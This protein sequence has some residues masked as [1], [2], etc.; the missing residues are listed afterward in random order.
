MVVRAW[1]CRFRRG[2]RCGRLAF[3]DFRCCVEVI[4]FG[5]VDSSTRV[6]VSGIATATSVSAGSFHSCALL[7]S[8]GVQCWGAGANG[9]LSNG[10][11]VDG[12]TPVAVF[13]ISNATRVGAGGSHTCARLTNGE[14]RCWRTNSSGQLGDGLSMLTAPVAQFVGTCTLDLDGDGIV[15]PTTDGLL[16]VRALL[17]VSGNAVTANATGTTAQRNTWLAIR[18][19]LQR[20]CGIQGLAP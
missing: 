15:S 5:T 1:S 2:S 17:G 13:R 7:T 18:T 16:L 10:G 6:A 9:R 14:I 12:S 20:T 3:A 19:H 8:G 11:T 4:L